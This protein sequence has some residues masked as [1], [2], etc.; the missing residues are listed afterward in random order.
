MPFDTLVAR[1]MGNVLLYEDV[2]TR[3]AGAAEEAARFREYLRDRQPA[4]GS[5]DYVRADYVR[6]YD[7]VRMH[8]LELRRAEEELQAEGERQARAERRATMMQTTEGRFREQL[9]FMGAEFVGLQEAGESYQV[10]WRYGGREYDMRFT[11]G[12]RLQAAGYCL[13]GRDSAHNAAS[14][15]AIMHEHQRR[16]RTY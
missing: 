6:A 16:G 14:V 4:V 3:L 7:V 15:V 2:A 5:Q 10:A 1:A 8:F 13:D 9:E 12:G 11:R